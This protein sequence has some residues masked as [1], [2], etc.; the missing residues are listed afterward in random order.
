MA[1][2]NFESQ[3]PRVV[4]ESGFLGLAGMLIVCA[5]ALVALQNARLRASP[6]E[7]SLLLATQLLLLPMFYSNVIFNHTASAFVWVIF[8]IV[9]ANL[10]PGLP[11][12]AALERGNK[13]K[14]RQVATPR[15]GT[16][17]A[18]GADGRRL[19]PTAGLSQAAR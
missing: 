8:A 18:T 9:L 3:M 17:A 5:G 15:S 4:M 14:P 6:A 16:N 13:L 19:H 10:K 2:T 11:A 12:V 1:F 7:S